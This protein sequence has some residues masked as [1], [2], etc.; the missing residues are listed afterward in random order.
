MGK[1]RTLPTRSGSTFAPDI[2][3]FRYGI[4]AGCP[5]CGFYVYV[6]TLEEALWWFKGHKEVGY[7]HATSR[8]V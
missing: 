7:C 2:T 8:T 6:S 3:E 1:I 4:E 5:Q